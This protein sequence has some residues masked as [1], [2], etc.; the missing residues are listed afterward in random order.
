[1]ETNRCTN[2]QLYSGTQLYMFWAV[3]L[4]ILRSYS[5]YIWHWHM[6]HGFDDSLRAV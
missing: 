5:L 2:I 4:P 3:S 1:M 6:L